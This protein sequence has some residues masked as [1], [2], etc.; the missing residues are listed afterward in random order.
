M[1]RLVDTFIK[2]MIFLSTSQCVKCNSPKTIK[3]IRIWSTA[4]IHGNTS[5]HISDLNGF[6]LCVGKTT[7]QGRGKTRVL[8]LAHEQMK[9]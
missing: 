3:C 6:S 8:A 9:G 1:I 7:Q 5:L 4:F 2:D